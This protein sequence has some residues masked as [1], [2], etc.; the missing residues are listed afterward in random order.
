LI[1]SPNTRLA[2]SAAAIVAG[3]GL[4]AIVGWVFDLEVLRSGVPGLVPIKPNAA[5]SLMAAGFSLWVLSIPTASKPL[6]LAGHTAAIAIVVLGVATHVEHTLGLDLG[7]GRLIMGSQLAAL[8]VDGRMADSTAGSLW[9]VGSAFLVARSPARQGAVL[10]ELAGVIALGISSIALFGYSY[11]ILSLN[12][13][14]SGAAMALN[15]SLALLVLSAGVL[16]LRADGPMMTFL[17]GP[18]TGRAHAR[19]MVP[20]WFAFA[21]ALGLLRVLSEWSGLLAAEMGLS[22][23]LVGMTLVLAVLAVASTRFLDRIDAERKQASR[24]LETSETRYRV[25]AETLPVSVSFIDTDHR[26]VYAND[27]FAGALGLQAGDLIGRHAADVLGAEMYERAQPTIQA[28]LAGAETVT[29]LE[30]DSGKQGRRWLTIRTVPAR[31]SD[32]TINGVLVV[33]TDDTEHHRL[34]QQKQDSHRLDAVG[35]LA[36]GVAHDFNNMLTVIRGVA[37]VLVSGDTLSESQREDLDEILRA[38]RRASELTRQLLAF[39]RRQMLSPSRLD[40]SALV[41]GNMNLLRRLVRE[42]IDL[43]LE[44]TDPVHPAFAD[45]A[46]IERVLMNLVLNARDAIPGPGRITIST[47]NVELFDERPGQTKSGSWV[48][49]KVADTGVGMDPGTL[50]RAF[51]PFFTTKQVGKGTGMGLSMAY[52]V[53]EQMGGRIFAESST[54]SGSTFTVLLP[55][56]DRP[57]E[58]TTVEPVVPST[59]I[60]GE[61]VLVVEDEAEVRSLVSRILRQE[62]CAVEVARN[63]REAL[64]VLDAFTSGFDLLITDV[65]MPG[66]SGIELADAVRKKYPGVNVLLMSGYALTEI[67]QRGG[68]PAKAGFLQKPFSVEGLRAAVRAAL[69]PTTH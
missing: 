50:E 29:D 27:R 68:L 51:E 58:A 39:G 61:R 8:N 43:V 53:V 54:A 9:I 18:L 25:I 21:L 60:T 11:G 17:S 38:A 40:M 49:L 23:L 6:S 42:D 19:R 2:R 34:Q 46:Q 52:G 67:E 64:G 41:E 26:Y 48:S 22:L 35:Q 20:F 66:M 62:G 31:D 13:V 1:D 3:L 36:G 55:R 59:R 57:E 30:V 10:L 47:A 15:T 14:D 44:L 69:F 32:G 45:Q 5:L 28:S 7:T 63:G 65:V 33:T 37:E 16:S 24:K 56:D 4:L 12:A